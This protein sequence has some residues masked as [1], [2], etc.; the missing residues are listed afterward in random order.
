MSGFKRFRLRLV[1]TMTIWLV[2]IGVG[3]LFGWV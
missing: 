1:L 2:L 3:R